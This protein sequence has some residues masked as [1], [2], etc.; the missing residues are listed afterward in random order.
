MISGVPG[1]GSRPGLCRVL[2]GGV[3][4]GVCLPGPLRLAG[5]CLAGLHG[6]VCL[7]SLPSGSACPPL[8]AGSRQLEK[9]WVIH[10]VPDVLRKTAIP[11]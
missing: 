9:S 8:L 1:P 3:L 11:M 7:P 6:G 2:P 5:P 10:T 4:P